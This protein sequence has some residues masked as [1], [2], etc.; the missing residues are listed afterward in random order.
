MKSDTKGT[1][2]MA[3]IIQEVEKL[4][5]KTIELPKLTRGIAKDATELIGNTPLVKLNRITIGIKAEVVA[6]CAYT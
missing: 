4:K 1:I 5:Y 6:T 3:G 2:T